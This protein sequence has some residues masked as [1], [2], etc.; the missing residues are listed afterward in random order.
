[1][2]LEDDRQPVGAR[3]RRFGERQERVRMHD[4]RS[5]PLEGGTKL[6]HVRGRASKAREPPRRFTPAAP[7][8]G[9][10]TLDAL[11]CDEL[12]FGPRPEGP[13]ARDPSARRPS[14]PLE[15][16]SHTE[17]G[18]SC[19]QCLPLVEEDEDPQESG[20]RRRVH[21]AGQ[22]GPLGEAWTPR[23]RNA[24]LSV[25]SE[26]FVQTPA[27]TSAERTRGFVGARCFS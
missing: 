20:R 14:V 17:H 22:P 9:E 16:P 3:D 4:V 21:H 19:A 7:A 24:F 11:D 23:F 13:I 2:D 6:A 1:V 18:D 10:G 25:E 8:E 12:L 15:L 27:Q 5:D 26:N